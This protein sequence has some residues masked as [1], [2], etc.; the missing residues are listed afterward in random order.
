MVA[1]RPEQSPNAI[2]KLARQLVWPTAISCALAAFAACGGSSEDDA[3]FDSPTGGTGGSL[4]VSGSTSGTTGGQSTGTSG[5]ATGGKQTGGQA[6]VGGDSGQDPEQ[7][8]AGPGPG[9]GGAPGMPGEPMHPPDGMAGAGGADAACPAEQPKDKAECTTVLKCEY[10]ELDCNCDGPEK[11]RR[12]HC[13][14]PPEPMDTCPPMA[15][16]AGAACV[17]VEDGPAAPPCHYQEPAVD[18]TCTADK[19]V[20]TEAP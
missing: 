20:C 19:W 11:D 5:S 9:A 4:G 12:W 15:P 1:P 16:K 2:S 17:S 10:A 14:A 13:K 8:G 18:C 7:G 3:D 6:S